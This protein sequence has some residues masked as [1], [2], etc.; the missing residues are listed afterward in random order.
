MTSI[1]T[2]QDRDTANR[3]AAWRWGSMI[4]GMLT[5]QVAGGIV[6]IVLATGD[7]SVAIVPNYHQKALNWDDEVALRNASARLGW[8][9]EMNPTDGPS[10]TAGLAVRLRDQ[11]GQLV[12][13]ESGSIEIYR[14][15]RAANVHRV[16]IPELS[17]G[18]I[19]LSECFDFG[20]LWQVSLDVHDTLGN[21]FV[22]SQEINVLLNH[23]EA[24]GRVP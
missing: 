24:M 16:R 14:H 4:V 19:D 12:E 6:A 8:V 22:D 7:E 11:N 18:A 10:G 23:E 3:R 2:Q 15:A 21:R 1:D 5:L 20:G 9:A 17:A 13:I